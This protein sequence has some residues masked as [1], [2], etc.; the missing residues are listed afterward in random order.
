MSDARNSELPADI[1]FATDE[2]G[3]R[4]CWRRAQGQ[5]PIGPALAVVGALSLT[6][7]SGILFLLLA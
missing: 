7:W 1:D 2:H 5:W 3:R 6:I 4:L